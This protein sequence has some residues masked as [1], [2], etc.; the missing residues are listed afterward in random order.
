MVSRYK[1]PIF[2]FAV[3]ILLITVYLS[4]GT[5]VDWFDLG[6]TI[7]EFRF[8]H[9]LVI[10]ASIFVTVHAP[11]Y[12]VLKRRYPQKAKLLLGIHVLGNLTSFLLISVHFAS[13][14]SRP[15]QFY[16]DLGTG[17][18]LYTTMLILVITGFAQRFQIA[19]KLTKKWRFIHTGFVM[20]VYLV[21][22]VHALQGLGYL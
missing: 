1:S 2:W 8:N 14:L 9:W 5:Y 4:Y 21:I 12:H 13:Q 22:V 16:P 19:P 7:G 11:L 17:I 18:V 15:Q 6:F 3:A 10:I 20:S